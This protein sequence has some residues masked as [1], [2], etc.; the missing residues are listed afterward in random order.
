MPLAIFKSDGQPVHFLVS[1]PVFCGAAF[2]AGQM[3]VVF[4]ERSPSATGD[5]LRKLP[6]TDPD[7]FTIVYEY[8]A[9][10]PQLLH[11]LESWSGV[12]AGT[13]RAPRV[14]QM[15]PASHSC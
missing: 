13:K 6:R 4:A 3:Y 1:E 12:R 14:S 10:Q 8:N 9:W 7:W 11:Q 2:K 15:N 5:A